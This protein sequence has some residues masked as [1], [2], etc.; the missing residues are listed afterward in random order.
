M[1][2]V[3]FHP[4]YS[5]TWPADHRFPMSKFR[6][7]YDYLLAEQIIVPG[8][9]VVPK[10]ASM[11]TVTRV[12]DPNY[13]QAFCD[14]TLEEKAVRR[15]G[16]HWYPDLVTRTFAEVGGTMETADLALRHGLACNTA[17]GTHHAF[18]NY[19]TGY[20]IF[21]DIAVAAKD[22]LAKGLVTKIL[23]VDL[24]VHQGDGTAFIF[25]NDQRVFTFSM[26]GARN[27]PFRKQESDL[28]IGLPNGTGDTEYLER[29]QAT[30]P[31]LLAKVQPDL[32]F[33]DAGVDVHAEDRLGKIA[34][35][36]EGIYQRDLSVL[37]T[38]VKAGIP[39]ATVVGGGYAMEKPELSPR[40]ALVFKAAKT[41]A[42]LLPPY[43]G[44]QSSELKT[45]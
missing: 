27:F 30:L 10:P 20:C 18:P 40:H 37:Q 24:D 39:V 13:V 12:H 23:V 28:D 22:L 44:K 29:L 8:Q 7:V 43:V 41:L 6:L 21:N 31:K 11:E 3:V 26:H 17:G 42:H 33:Y 9:V 36:S 4:N 15:I 16:M 35:T 32:V 25:H 1:F 45:S 34:L 5:I 14:G 38:C 19:G 2:P